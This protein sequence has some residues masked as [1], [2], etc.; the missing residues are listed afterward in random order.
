MAELNDP[1]NFYIT[2]IPFVS[3]TPA[4]PEW[5]VNLSNHSYHIAAY[6]TG[7]KASYTI[8]GK[9]YGIKQG[10]FLFFPKNKLHAGLSDPDDPWS[11]YVVLFDA[12]FPDRASEETFLQVDCVTKAPPIPTLFNMFQ[13]IHYEW[14]ARKPNFLLRCRCRIMEIFCLLIRQR[15]IPEADARIAQRMDSILKRIAENYGDNFSI[16]E[17]S[18]MAGYSPSHFQLVFKKVTGRTVIQYQNEMKIHKA[19]DLLIYDGCNVTEAAGRVGMQDIYYF[20]KLFKQITGRN[21]S[22]YTRK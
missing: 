20:S 3:F 12:Q 7:G 2:K 8:D 21:P 9:D 22:D 6:C 10:D 19:R 18:R 16:D 13:D 14:S 17:L 4:N 15:Q 5:K 11:F 1:F